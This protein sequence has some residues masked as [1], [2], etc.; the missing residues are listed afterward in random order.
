MTIYHVFETDRGFMGFVLSETGLKK[1]Y[2]P[3]PSVDRVRDT[4]QRDYPDARIAMNPLP[5]L[6]EQFRRYFAGEPV[7]FNVPLDISGAT[8]FEIDVWN[9]CRKL[10]Y[11]KTAS[12]KNLA[13]TVNRPRAARAVGS[14]MR[15]NRFP[16]I[17]PCHRVLRSDGDIGQYSG[18]GGADF[19]RELL[20]LEHVELEQNG[21]VC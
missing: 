12:Y 11:G 20:Q 8:E 9:A 1:V 6:V 18:P 13:E 10:G 3:Q 7:E 2:L 19:K 4:V 5:E 17:V 21:G 16:I 15:R 14:A